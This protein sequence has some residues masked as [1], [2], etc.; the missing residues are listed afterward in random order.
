MGFFDDMKNSLTEKS[1]DLSKKAKD[2]TEIYRLNN[3]NKSM[4]KEVEKLIYQIGLRY[5]ANY[6]DECTEKCPD[7]I[8]QIDQLYQTMEANKQQI[9]Q[10]SIVEVCPN[11]GKKLDPNAKFCVNCGTAINREPAPVAPNPSGK[12]CAS[13]GTPLEDDAAFCTNCGTPVKND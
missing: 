7:L 10:L 5:Y 6:K 13:C 9:E 1:Q 12:V 4:E 11:C 2:T 8:E 3:A